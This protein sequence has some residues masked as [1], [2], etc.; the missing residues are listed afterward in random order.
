VQR[1][2]AVMN[3]CPPQPG[4]FTVVV[5]GGLIQLE[6]GQVVEDRHSLQPGSRLAEHVGGAM[7]CRAV[8][9]P[10]CIAPLRFFRPEL[11]VLLVGQRFEAFEKLLREPRSGGGCQFQ[12]LGFEFLNA[13]DRDST[14]S[15]PELRCT[16]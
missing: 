14:P 15:G 4:S 13:H 8:D 5:F 12:R 6:L 9:L 16:D 1:S 11:S 2:T 3:A 10:R 7:T